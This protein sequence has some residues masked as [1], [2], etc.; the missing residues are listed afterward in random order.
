MQQT[1]RGEQPQN[2]RIVEIHFKPMIMRENFVTALPHPL[3]S[4]AG[5]C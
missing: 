5:V 1:T 4:T 3:V 2:F